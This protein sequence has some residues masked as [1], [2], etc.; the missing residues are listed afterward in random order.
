[1][2][3]SAPWIR[4]KKVTETSLTWKFLRRLTLL[5]FSKVQSSSGLRTPITQRKMDKE[6][7]YYAGVG[8]RRAGPEILSFFEFCGGRLKELGY[9]LRSGAAIGCD[10]A[11][12]LKAGTEAQIFVAKKSLLATHPHYYY[13]DITPDH[14]AYKL[15]SQIH[16]AWGA[17]SEYARQL[18]A[19]NCF[20]VLGPNLDDPSRFLLCWTP[21]G[22]QTAQECNINTGGTATAIRLAHKRGIPIFNFARPDCKARFK[23]FIHDQP[24]W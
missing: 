7:R 14:P 21:C 1:M 10:S 8:S 16:P 20:Q 9:T 24:P 22:S 17:C 18:H 6:R 19:R 11:F 15:A 3:C 12:E 5:F 13:Q 2:F 4:S 23:T